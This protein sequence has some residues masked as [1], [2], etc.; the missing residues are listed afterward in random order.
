M[1]SFLVAIAAAAAAAEDVKRT[2]GLGGARGLIRGGAETGR[3]RGGLRL[4][5]REGEGDGDEDDL[6]ADDDAVLALGALEGLFLTR[7]G[8]P[9]D[10]DARRRTDVEEDPF[11]RVADIGGFEAGADAPRA[12]SF[13]R[14]AR[15]RIRP[16]GMASFEMSLAIVPPC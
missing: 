14:P 8:D 2:A 4:R 9:P 3:I 11:V 7:L 13:S 6:E 5:G 16:S 15:L 1:L 12:S 10:M